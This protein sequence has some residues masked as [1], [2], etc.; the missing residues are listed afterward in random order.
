MPVNALQQSMPVN[1]LQQSMPVNALQQSIT[2]QC[3]AAVNA[4]QWALQQS[5]PVNALQQSI[6]SQ[7]LAAVNAGQCLA[8]VNAGQCLAAVNASQCLRW[9]QVAVQVIAGEGGCVPVDSTSLKPT[10]AVAGAQLQLPKDVLEGQH[11]AVAVILHEHLHAPVLQVQAH[12]R[13]I[14]RARAGRDG[15]GN[16]WWSSIVVLEPAAEPHRCAD[17]L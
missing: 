6:T 12:L 5:K 7:C 13:E 1:A 2:S 8:A 14:Q 10:C 17:R 11:Q 15:Y 3:L 9:A 16:G 4:S